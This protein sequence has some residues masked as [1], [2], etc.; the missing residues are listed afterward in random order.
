VHYG[1]D[2][3]PKFSDDMQPKFSEMNNTLDERVD[4]QAMDF[5]STDCV[6]QL[7]LEISV[8]YI[9]GCSLNYCFSGGILNS[10]TKTSLDTNY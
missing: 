9:F 7:I 8:Y 6:D 3:Q 10:N 2:M 1:D 5:L 4:D